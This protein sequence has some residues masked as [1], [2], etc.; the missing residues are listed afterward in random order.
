MLQWCVFDTKTRISK[1]DWITQHLHNFV[2][3]K[4]NAFVAVR[5]L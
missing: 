1:H 4:S 2:L 5:Y 3:H